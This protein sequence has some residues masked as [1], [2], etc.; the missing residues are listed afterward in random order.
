MKIYRANLL[1]TPSVEQFVTIPDGYIVI[2]DNGIIEGVF[3]QLPE[4]YVGAMVEDFGN[5]M[6]IPGFTDLHLHPN[7]FPDNGLG[8]DY[9][10]L[11][12]IDNYA[13]RA[14]LYYLD[15]EK[16]ADIFECFAKQLLKNGITR[17]VQFG[18]ISKRSTEILFETMAKTGLGAY[19]GKNNRDYYAFGEAMETLEQSKK[20]TMELIEKYGEKYPLLRYILTPCF[21]P[22]CTEELMQWVGEKAREL[23]IPVQTHLDEN[24]GEVEQVIKRFP[25]CSDYGNVYEKM[26]MF[27]ETIPTVM[28]HC[29]FTTEREISMLRDKNVFVAHCPHSNFNLTSGVMPLRR[30]LEEGIHVGIG[31]D[32]SA[33]HTLNMFDNMRAVLSGSRYRSV[34]YGEKELSAVESFY[35]ATR[36]GG[37]FFG[38]VGSFE[39]GFVF[40]ALLVDDDS[41]PDF[42][43]CSLKERLERLIYL[44]DDRQIKK[45]FCNGQEV[46]SQ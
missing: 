44:G 2:D 24:R 46:Y 41:V 45:V 26:D 9:E 37:E 5:K 15:E 11:P 35:L 17:S 40:D 28:A 20:A 36:G 12:W 21:V 34:L 38:K 16:A 8:Y 30:Y 3:E 19:I 42:R 18:P 4:K 6:L 39:A 43:G 27:D 32:I 31:S 22:G 29:I 33:G 10:L 14:E 23:K 25:K 1:F 13:S 7:Q